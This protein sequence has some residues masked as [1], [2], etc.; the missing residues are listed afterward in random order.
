[1]NALTAI[2]RDVGTDLRILTK[3]YGGQL[4]PTY[5]VAVKDRYFCVG[6][7]TLNQL[8][9]GV[10]PDELGLFEVDPDDSPSEDY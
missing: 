1:M 3:R 6:Q 7:L 5:T 4:G 10:S 8:Q 9:R 2:L